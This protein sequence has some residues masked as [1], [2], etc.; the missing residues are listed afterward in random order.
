M[1]STMLALTWTVPAVAQSTAPAHAAQQP[2]SVP[3]GP[4]TP[5]LNRLAAQRRVSGTMAVTNTDAAL[6]FLE[7]ALGIRTNHVGPLIVIRN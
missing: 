6:A 7:Q 1:A 2:I 5:A 3:A 4:L